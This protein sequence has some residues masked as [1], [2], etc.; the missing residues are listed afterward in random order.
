MTREGSSVVRRGDKIVR[1]WTYLVH[2]ETRRSPMITSSMLRVPPRLAKPGVFALA[3]LGICLSPSR[4]ILTKGADGNGTRV[5]SSSEVGRRCSVHTTR[6]VDGRPMGS[7]MIDSENEGGVFGEDDISPRSLLSWIY[8][9]CF[10]TT[11][12]RMSSDADYGSRCI[13]DESGGWGEMGR[14]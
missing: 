13:A 6:P 12:P 4:S 9:E 11:S 14:V 2:V 7:G 10:P 3:M 8:F 1:L 5:E